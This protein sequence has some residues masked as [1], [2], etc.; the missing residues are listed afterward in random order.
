MPIT[1]KYPLD[2][3]IAA[4]KRYPTERGREITA[5]YVLLAG[6]NDSPRD[7]IALAK[8]LRGV[9]TKVNAIP[10][11]EDPN[12]PP[13]MKRPSDRAIDTFVETLV[14]HGVPVTVRRSKGRDIA[15]ACGQLRGRTEPR[16]KRMA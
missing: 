5:E 6:W 15:A 11:N 14:E 10:F 1:K 3:L 9:H 8:L 7:A 13:W 16:R 12:L 4:L 2:E